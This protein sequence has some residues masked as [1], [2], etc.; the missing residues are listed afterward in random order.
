MLI[1][2]NLKNFLSFKDEQSFTVAANA[3]SCHENEHLIGF[4]KKR[5]SK[6][7]VMYGANASGK[8]NFVKAFDFVKWFFINSNNLLETTLIPI[9]TF[10]FDKKTANAPAEFGIIFVKDD[11]KYAYSFACTKN[12]VTKEH[13]DIYENGKPALVFDRVKND[14]KFNSYAKELEP[15]VSRNTKNKLFICTAAT[16]NF[17]KAKPVVDFIINDLCISFSYDTNLPI[18][19]EAFKANGVYDRYKGFCLSLLNACDFSIDDF[20][21]EVKEGKIP[22]ELSSLLNT[23]NPNQSLVNENK[24]RVVKF[25]TSHAIGKGASK[26]SFP[27]SLELESLGTRAIFNFA[28]LLFDV[29]EHGKTL[30][31]DEINKSLHPLLVT[32]IVSLFADPEI[33]KN[34]AQLICN[35]HDT[36][37]LSLDIF[38]RDEIW[39]AERDSEFG[40]S[41]IYPLT[42]FSPTKKENIEKG[43]LIGR[44]GAIPFIKDMCNLWD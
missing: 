3:D 32:Y 36:N 21:M 16:W 43:Y 12:E 24:L 31:L 2:F 39:F 15:I 42:D 37:L 11:I 29:L 17:A 9:T 1:Q 25:N 26:K 22:P 20:E 40:N 28:P 41:V 10:T 6:L 38:R 44:Y 33:N 30:V 18:M 7:S 4:R 35:T 27:L 14:Y 34:N 13:L 5:Y 8:T 23:L 19:L